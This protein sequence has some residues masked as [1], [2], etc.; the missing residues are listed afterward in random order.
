[1][2]LL[3]LPC[4]GGG[5]GGGPAAVAAAAVVAVDND[6]T[7]S[8]RYILGYLA[9]DKKSTRKLPANKNSTIQLALMSTSSVATMGMF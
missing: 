1:V 9:G 8:Q 3:L 4:G 6:C 7:T 2:V 5:S